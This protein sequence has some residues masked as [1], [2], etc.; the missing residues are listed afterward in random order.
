ML[1]KSE[2]VEHRVKWTE[3][4]NSHQKPFTGVQQSAS[5]WGH[6]DCIDT[7]TI[8]YRSRGSQHCEIHQNIERNYPLK[9]T[10]LKYMSVLAY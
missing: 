1:C 7:Q 10:L 2:K 4:C 6:S 5:F 3:I 8:M 9:F